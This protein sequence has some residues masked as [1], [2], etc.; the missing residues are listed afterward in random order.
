VAATGFV[1][2]H[3]GGLAALSDVSFV[4]DAISFFGAG[5][6]TDLAEKLIAILQSPEEQRQL[7]HH[8]FSAAMRMTMPSVVRHYLRWFDLARRKQAVGDMIEVPSFRRW[9]RTPIGAYRSSRNGSRRPVIAEPL[10]SAVV[11]S[12]RYLALE[13]SRRNNGNGR[14]VEQDSHCPVDGAKSFD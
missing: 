8:N 1:L 11:P 13:K 4:V 9:L 6:P 14:Y 12:K 3:F 10:D 2:S 5:N 7:A